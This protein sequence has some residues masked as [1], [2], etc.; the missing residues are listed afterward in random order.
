M[1]EIFKTILVHAMLTV[2]GIIVGTILSGVITGD[3]FNLNDVFGAI[4]LSPIEMLIAL[5]RIIYMETMIE[6][7]VVI[8]FLIWMFAIVLRF[9]KKKLSN[10]CTFTGAVL[11]SLD[12]MM[13]FWM[14]MSV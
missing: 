8:G 10:L 2:A 11:W 1:K 13:I 3:E 4:T 7:L 5:I 9:K 12:N 14:I 6:F